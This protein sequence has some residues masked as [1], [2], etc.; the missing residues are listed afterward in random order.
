LYF[1][2]IRER[3]F[4]IVGAPLTISVER[5]VTECHDIAL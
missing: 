5:R 3:S 2:W 1:E 4:H